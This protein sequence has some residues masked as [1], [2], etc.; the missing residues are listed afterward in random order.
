MVRAPHACSFTAGLKD[1]AGGASGIVLDVDDKLLKRKVRSIARA[2]VAE[3]CV[4]SLRI[5]A[6]KNRSIDAIN[7]TAVP[8][9]KTTSD[10]EAL[11][12]H[13]KGNCDY[14]INPSP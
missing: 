5:D 9:P 11:F 3:L 2:D 4:Q 10:I 8:T 7:D 12:K 14:S 1:A 6:A 13:L